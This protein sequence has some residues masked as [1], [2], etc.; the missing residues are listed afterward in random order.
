V[1]SETH[2]AEL[3]ADIEDQSEATR[4]LYT[5]LTHFL[6]ASARL[7][8]GELPTLLTETPIGETA[9]QTLAERYRDQAHEIESTR[10][11]SVSRRLQSPR[12]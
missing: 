3:V 2:V 11:A 9:M 7:D 1:S 8:E 6:S 5:L 4:I 12:M 10:V